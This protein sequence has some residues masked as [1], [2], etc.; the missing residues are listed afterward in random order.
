[1]VA[2]RVS[3]N[4]VSFSGLV[5]DLVVSAGG[6]DGVSAGRLPEFCPDVPGDLRFGRGACRDWC[7]NTGGAATAVLFDASAEAEF[8][9]AAADVALGDGGVAEAV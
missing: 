1:M 6:T 4:H 7:R 8:S 3:S 9:V 5:C 2:G